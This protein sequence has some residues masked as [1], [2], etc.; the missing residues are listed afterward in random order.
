VDVS[1]VTAVTVTDQVAPARASIRAGRLGSLEIVREIGSGATGNVF[2][3][4]APTTGVHYVIKT[5][6][7]ETRNTI[8]LIR[9]NREARL[10]AG[11]RHPNLMP[12]VHVATTNDP[13]FYVMPLRPGETL[14]A[15]TRDGPLSIAAVTRVA[16]DVCY[17]LA[18]VHRHGIVHRD[19]KPANIMIEADGRAVLIDFGLA[20]VEGSGEA[21]VT[22]QGSLLGTPGY[23]SPEQCLGERVSDRSD[24]YSLGVTIMELLL[25]TNPFITPS[26]H[27]TIKRHL[28]VTPRRLDAC[29]P[30][31]VSE[32]LG[33]LV[34]RMIAKRP[35][36]RP[37]AESCLE[38]FAGLTRQNEMRAARAASENAETTGR[39]A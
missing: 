36:Q 7:P 29:L 21:S 19:I 6:R 33:E 18:E 14:L 23:M 26:L 20:K 12:I 38:A 31:R 1:V 24:V 34:H 15:K 22:A 11:L 3:A 17:G 28:E 32:E 30:G 39:I 4:I 2:E 35:T 27:L 25:G 8:E 16:R 13:P 37:K 5:L 9:F 10:M